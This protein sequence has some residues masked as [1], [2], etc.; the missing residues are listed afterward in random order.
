MLLWVVE[1]FRC[2]EVVKGYDNRLKW[3]EVVYISFDCVLKV[4][5][6]HSL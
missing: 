6:F 4:I 1:S 5:G 3:F 2:F